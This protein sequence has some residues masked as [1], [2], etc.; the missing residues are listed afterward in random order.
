LWLGQF[1]GQPGQTFVFT[2]I[3]SIGIY[4]P[5]V[6]AIYGGALYWMDPS[7]NFHVYQPGGVPVPIPCPLQV[8]R[9]AL[10]SN[11]EHAVTRRRYGEIWFFYVSSGS[12][13]TSFA[14]YCVH[15]SQT[16]GR[17]IWFK[18]TMSAET[19]IDDSLLNDGLNMGDS[20]CIRIAG[21]GSQKLIAI[22]RQDGGGTAIDWNLT[23]SDYYI[24]EGER[25]SMITRYYH[26]VE[27]QDADI[28]LTLRAR[29][30]PN[31]TN[32]SVE[33]QTV[34]ASATKK[35][36]RASGKLIS[37]KLAGTDLFRLG[38]PAFDTVVLGKR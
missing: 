16:Q 26:D 25:R 8:Q 20:T 6:F 29:D 13:P 7:L 3:A 9:N 24:D 34:A 27:R 19:A 36:F 33:V 10:L 23:T 30:H 1:I 14:A 15:E 32:N 17:P 12:Y 21:G 22:D 38:R 35:D 28:T 18:G 11:V 37:Y 31:D 4:S 5:H 2:R